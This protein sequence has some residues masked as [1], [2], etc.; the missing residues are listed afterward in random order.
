M[1]DGFKFSISSETGAA[2]PEEQ[3][4]TTGPSAKLDMMKAD[5]QRIAMA[6]ETL[7]VQF[8]GIKA[9][10]DKIDK[11]MIEIAKGLGVEL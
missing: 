11:T 1:E 5:I 3:S 10:V 8:A 6:V 4:R 2:G 9:G 7:V